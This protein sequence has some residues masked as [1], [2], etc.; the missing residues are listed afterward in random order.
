[1]LVPVGDE[2]SGPKALPKQRIETLGRG[3][4]SEF[5]RIAC[6]YEPIGAAIIRL[7]RSADGTVAF[8][9]KE[10]PFCTTCKRYFRLKP[11]LTIVGIPLEEAPNAGQGIATI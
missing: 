8:E 6:P 4:T 5:H 3:K 9:A 2:L 7:D 11:K 1:M 10:P